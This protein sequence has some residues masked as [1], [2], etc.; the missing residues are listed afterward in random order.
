MGWPGRARRHARTPAGHRRPTLP[1]QSEAERQVQ[2]RLARHPYERFAHHPFAI[3]IAALPGVELRKHDIGR[4][5]LRI[6]RVRGHIFGLGFAR[7]PLLRVE[8]AQVDPGLWSVGVEPLRRD[9][10]LDGARQPFDPPVAA[11]PAASPPAARRLR[12][13]PRTGSSSR[14]CASG[15]V[16]AA[17]SQRSA[18]SAPSRTSG[19]AS[20][21]PCCAAPAASGPGCVASISKAVARTIA[22]APARSRAATAAAGLR[23]AVPC[24]GKR[25]GPGLET[26]AL[27]AIPA[28]DRGRRPGG[29]LVG[30]A[31]V[32]GI[33]DAEA[34]RE[35]RPRHAEAMIVA[36]I[37]HHIGARRHVAGRAARRRRALRMMVVR[38]GGVLGPS[39][40]WSRRR[41]LRRAASANA[42]RGNRCRSRPA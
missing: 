17:G 9:V 13:G 6:E 11:D 28:L 32:A 15:Q 26:L 35:V 33:G 3:G 23:S 42:A 7:L 38:H 20:A 1:D 39:W 37:D 29:V 12:A 36:R 16:C 4:H 41:C 2:F 14:P 21:R 25:L 19:S 10:G 34:D 30:V 31:V 5:E 24:G 22:G 40:H 18:R 27:R 8:I